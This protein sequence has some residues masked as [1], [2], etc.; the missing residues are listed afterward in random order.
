MGTGEKTLSILSK[1]Y[2]GW[3]E[4]IEKGIYG[5]SQEGK[6]GLEQYQ[7]LAIL[8]RKMIESIE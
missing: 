2:N 1:N 3:F 4:R 5:L 7:A 6:K 8:Y